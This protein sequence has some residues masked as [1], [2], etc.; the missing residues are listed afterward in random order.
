MLMDSHAPREIA[1]HCGWC[2]ATRRHDGSWD[3]E[4]GTV[5]PELVTHGICPDC[6]EAFRAGVEITPAAREAAAAGHLRP[7]VT[8]R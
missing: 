7:A 6:A 4:C 1:C 3:D 2:G 8:F 5:R